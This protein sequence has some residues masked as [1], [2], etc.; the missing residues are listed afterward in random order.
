M[1][2]IHKINEARNVLESLTKMRK[3]VDLASGLKIWLELPG[4]DENN[5]RQSADIWTGEN[6]EKILDEIIVAA[7]KS[8][9]FRESMAKSEFRELK[10]YFELL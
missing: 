10:E 5:P 9:E 6:T 1:S 4:A 2:H 7:K 3:S 8:L